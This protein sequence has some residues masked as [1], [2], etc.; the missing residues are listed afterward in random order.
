LMAEFSVVSP[1]TRTKIDAVDIV[2]GESRKDPPKEV[3]A[4][5]LPNPLYTPASFDLETLEDDREPKLIITFTHTKGMEAL[6]EEYAK[7]TSD[8]MNTVE[9]NGMLASRFAE[10]YL[11]NRVGNLSNLAAEMRKITE[12]ALN[13]SF[14]ETINVIIEAPAPAFGYTGALNDVL[15]SVNW[16]DKEGKPYDAES[17]GPEDLSPS[18]HATKYLNNGTLNIL[19][20]SPQIF[21]AEF[22]G[23]LTDETILP[24]MGPPIKH[25]DRVVT[26]SA[27]GT[28]V[29]SNLSLQTAGDRE[30]DQEYFFN[31]QQAGLDLIERV[32][33]SPS[34]NP[35]EDNDSDGFEYS[36]GGSRS[37]NS[38]SGSL[39]IA[40]RFA[41]S[42][43]ACDCSCD[44][45]WSSKKR[46]KSRW[47]K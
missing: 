8:T 35:N 20:F 23:R 44:A 26:G 28:I 27:S 4:P 15:I 46:S 14:N 40:N 5:S 7:V 13:N 10:E 9:S 29:I 2:K 21:V 19:E 41:A 33:K 30:L 34:K 12:N 25:L 39:G 43:P 3:R 18:E 37:G 16:S 36:S 47:I 17:I 32:S 38:G 1:N 22:S 24:P 6:Y 31:R 42:A 11:D 45:Y